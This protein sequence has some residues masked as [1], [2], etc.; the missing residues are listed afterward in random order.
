MWLDYTIRVWLPFLVGLIDLGFDKNEALVL[1]FKEQFIFLVINNMLLKLSVIILR[2][3]FEFSCVKHHK[4]QN[5]STVAIG[6]QTT[7]CHSKPFTGCLCWTNSWCCKTS[8]WLSLQ[9]QWLVVVAGPVSGC[10]CKTSECLLLH[11]Q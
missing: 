4:L 8:Y 10:H 2:A 3:R 6:H 1:V 7:S 9:K 11:Y 5:Q